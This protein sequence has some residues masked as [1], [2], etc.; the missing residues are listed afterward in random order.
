MSLAEERPSS[1]R[2]I[3]NPINNSAISAR[4]FQANLM[5]L[6]FNP[7]SSIS[8]VLTWTVNKLCQHLCK[9]TFWGIG[10]INKQID[11]LYFCTMMS[12]FQLSHKCT[13]IRSLT[14]KNWSCEI[15]LP[16]KYNK[17]FNALYIFAL[18]CV[19]YSFL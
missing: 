14:K 13:K 11:N 4:E 9:S 17:K 8:A 19:L 6:T 15:V 5:S 12:I 2:Q 7:T 1:V 3:S 10:I 18:L 16:I